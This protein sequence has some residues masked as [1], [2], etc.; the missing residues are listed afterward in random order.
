[1]LVLGKHLGI[2]KP[3]GPIINGCCCLG[4]KVRSLLEPLGLQC[5][6]ID[7]FTLYHKLHGEVHCGTIV[8]RQTFSFR[9]WNVV[10]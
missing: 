8:R 10:P 6:F 5:T 1:M 7:D 9:W 4:E 2:P 3:F